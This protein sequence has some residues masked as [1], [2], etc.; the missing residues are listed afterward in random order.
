VF[1]VGDAQATLCVVADGMGGEVAGEEA[2]SLAIQVFREHLATVLASHPPTSDAAWQTALRQS[3][4]AANQQVFARSRSEG[5]RG[6]GTTFTALIVIG[7]RAH[8]GHVGD[9]RAYLIN[10]SGATADGVPW[11]QLSSDHS[12]VARLVDI[13][14]IT[15]DE[16]RAHPHRNVLYRAIGTD[17]QVD[18]DAASYAVQPGDTLLICS[19]GLTNYLDDAELARMTSAAPSLAIACERLI[20]LANY[21]GGRDN[22]TVVLGRVAQ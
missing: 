6:M 22:S 5:R 16:A 2:S 1:A 12:L 17:P 9:S 21:R 15:A 11:L 18:A 13:G 7:N 19:D 20:A 8:L 14:Q 10:P 3:I 4:A